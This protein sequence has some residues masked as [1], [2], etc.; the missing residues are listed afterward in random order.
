[1]DVF[2]RSYKESLDLLGAVATVSWLPNDTCRVLQNIVSRIDQDRR[3]IMF[4]R[5]VESSSEQLIRWDRRPWTVIF[6]HGF[7]PREGRIDAL[8]PTAQAF[9]LS[10]YVNQND[11]SI[12]VSTSHLS[13]WVP[14]GLPSTIADNDY[15]YR[16]NLY[17]PGGIDINIAIA[18]INPR[19]R[20][21]Q[22]VVFPGGIKP[23]FIHSVD[24]YSCGALRTWQEQG[25]VLPLPDQTVMNKHFRPMIG[26]SPHNVIYHP[27]EQLGQ[28]CYE[29][30]DGRYDPSQD[31]DNHMHARSP[32]ALLPRTGPGATFDYIIGGVAEISHWKS[33]RE[34]GFTTVDAVLPVCGNKNQAYFFSGDF[35]ILVDFEPGKYD[36]L[37]TQRKRIVEEWQSLK[38]AEFDTVNAILP[39][40]GKPNQA[41]FF[42]YER[43]VTID[44]GSGLGQDRIEF[45]PELV[46]KGWPS[47]HKANF[48]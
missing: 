33:L 7:E 28:P 12:F 26:P 6:E 2:R 47:L 44:V 3:S 14:D 38:V 34:A 4:R 10:R 8:P 30:R 36:R 31:W 27:S 40:P 35:F 17:V 18:N 42:S 25:G 45:G 39:V 9:T 1:M 15:L 29:H 22:E 20:R 23:R 32:L 21:Q 11:P 5:G 46:S 19:R 16:Y 48:W 43:Y 41:F 37:V 13:T 24:V